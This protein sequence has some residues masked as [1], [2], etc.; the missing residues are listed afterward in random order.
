MSNE[1]QPTADEALLR[2]F[3]FG[4]SDEGWTEADSEEA[5]R[6]LPILVDAGYAR[7]PSAGDPWSVWS[8]TPAGVARHDALK[9]G[10]GS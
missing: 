9:A 3:D 10:P 2:S 6:L 4:M 8:F 1:A 5:G 7:I